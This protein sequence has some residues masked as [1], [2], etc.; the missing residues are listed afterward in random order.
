MANVPEVPDPTAVPEAITHGGT[1]F[2]HPRGLFLLFMVEM[3]ERFSYYGMRGLLVLYLATVM[4]VKQ[5]PQGVYENT[6]VFTQIQAA[7]SKGAE[8]V[9]TEFKRRHVVVVGAGQPST[10]D[11]SKSSEFSLLAQK[12]AANPSQDPQDLN[13]DWIVTGAE[14]GADHIVRVRDGKVEN[15]TYAVR[16]TNP[17]SKAIK[18]TAEIERKPNPAGGEI[19]TRTYFTINDSSSVVSFD[20][21]PDAE[22]T[23]DDP[24]Y[25]FII[26]AHEEDS[27]RN[28]TDGEAYGLYGWYTG[29]AYLLPILGGL[30]ADKLIGTHRSMVVGALLITLGHIVLGVSGL[31]AMAQNAQGMSVFVF[32]L[33]LIT[34]GTGHFKPS[35]SV[36]VGQLY[37]H[38]DPRRESAFSIFY[39]GINLGAF[40]CN[41]ICGYL[42]GKYGWHFGFG[43]AAIGMI[44]GLLMYVAFKAQ[45]LPGIGEST[46]SHKNKAWVFLPVGV[47]L[48]AMIGALFN[49]GTLAMVNEF[50]SH[51]IVQVII[52]IAA[53]LWVVQFVMRQEP[54]DRGPVATIFLYMLFNAIFWLSFEQ[55]GS[56]LN[57]FT[58]RNTDRMLGSTEIQTPYFQS[59]NPLLIILLAP[60][61][62]LLWANMARRQ[63]SIAQPV[64]IGLGLIFV[65]LGYLVMVFAAM[66]L[67]TGVAKVGMIYICGCYF[68]HT[69]GEI[70]LSP[71]GLSYVAK[72]APKRHVSG[73]M[74]MWFL[75]S[76]V[77]GLGAGQI[78]RLVEPI[79]A[80]EI[81]LPWKIGGQADFFLLFVISSVAAGVLVIA[82]S[83]LLTRLQ[84]SKH[85]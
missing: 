14:S 63:R 15:G 12:L 21:K 68:L 48:A 83:P 8:A 35:V 65:G 41:L 13:D 6:L 32:G 78:A 77:A 37:A 54:H 20:V 11:N 58:N 57:Q 7:E 18:V 72:T 42:A 66:R 80:G 61:F 45:Y 26:K 16:F 62:G 55:A 56:S 2:G 44:L 46:N 3:W 51:P 33:A 23:K 70:I 10:L 34:I 60:I 52:G 40:L 81:S 39:M 9:K 22:R 79:M 29:M 43:A 50:F 75:S 28:W 31:G 85:D 17:T 82:L 24:P 53:V 4:S 36:M 49:L 30:I 71:T 27:G 47:A 19:T 1:M 76:F 73:L 69:V 59:I 25:D 5:A 64:K 38:N 67:N 74:G 84:R